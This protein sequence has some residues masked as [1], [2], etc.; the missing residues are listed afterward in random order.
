MFT[1]AD[2]AFLISRSL[3]LLKEFSHSSLLV[4]LA[5]TG[6]AVAV[7]VIDRKETSRETINNEVSDLQNRLKQLECILAQHET[8]VKWFMNSRRLNENVAIYV[9]TKFIKEKKSK[10][11]GTATVLGEGATAFKATG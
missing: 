6:T 2:V 11:S 10:I 8:A 4:L 7:S 1:T 9:L 5:A 3:S